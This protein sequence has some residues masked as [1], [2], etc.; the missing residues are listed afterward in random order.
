[1]TDYPAFPS[2]TAPS[3]LGTW[4]ASIHDLYAGMA[5]QA[6][7]QKIN[8]KPEGSQGDIDSLIDAQLVVDVVIQAHQIAFQMRKFAAVFKRSYDS[9]EDAE[10]IGLLFDTKKEL[11]TLGYTSYIAAIRDLLNG[12]L[13]ENPPDIDPSEG[14]LTK[15]L[16]QSTP[17]D[18]VNGPISSMHRGENLNDRL[19]AAEK[20]HGGKAQ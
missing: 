12:D 3:I 5:M 20:K 2:S 13:W 17:F 10:R 4:G 15:E 14:W 18:N 1:M 6:L 19:R 11:E 7:I 9:L 8:V 16:M